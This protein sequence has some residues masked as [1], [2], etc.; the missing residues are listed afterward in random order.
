MPS[1]PTRSLLLQS[2][3]SKISTSKIGL[4]LAAAVGYLLGTTP[5]ADIAGRIATPDTIDLRE[6]GTGNPGATNAAHV[7]GKKWGV[8]VLAA[9]VAKA[10]LASAI[11][12]TLAGQVGANAAATSAVIGHCYP[13]W[14]GG[15]GGKGVAASIGQVVGTFP[16][17]LPLDIAVAVGTA[18]TPSLKE[19]AFVANSVASA[20]WVT[21]SYL[22]WK[23]GWPTG[24]DKKAHVSLPIG[25]AISSVSIASKFLSN[26]IERDAQGNAVLTE[27]VPSR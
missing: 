13:A 19:R 1:K 2:S 10:V 26:P 9:D 18:A 6:A 21:S 12:R 25:A 27:R 4:P 16:V 24:W 15:T 8:A 23:K 20:V 11:G 22:S 5:S 3:I 14:P 17:Y 7:L